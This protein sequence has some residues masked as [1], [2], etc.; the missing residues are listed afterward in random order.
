MFRLA[1]GFASS[2]MLG[3]SHEPPKTLKS[4]ITFQDLLKNAQ[5]AKLIKR[6]LPKSDVRYWR[7][8]IKLPTYT[9]D[10]KTIQSPH[11]SVC[12]TFKGQRKNLSH[13]WKRG[14][15]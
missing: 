3:Q 9:K 10:G 8:R 14:T 2:L 7:Q 1:I 11:Y 4:T 13:N 15:C 12:I 6:N 5:A